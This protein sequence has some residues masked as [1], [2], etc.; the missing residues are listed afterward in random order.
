MGKYF[1]YRQHKKLPKLNCPKTRN[2][3]QSSTNISKQIFSTP[4][5]PARM[6]EVRVPSSF[7]RLKKYRIGD[8]IKI[9]FDSDL[10][11]KK[12]KF[13]ERHHSVKDADTYHIK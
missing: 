13:G 4:V 6:Q 8:K 10:F 11:D 3:N 5:S 12:T 1:K 7:N 9:E 2:L